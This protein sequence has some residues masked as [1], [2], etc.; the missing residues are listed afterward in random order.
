MTATLDEFFR[1]C[2]TPFRSMQGDIS[3]ILRLIE[4]EHSCS[5]TAA[6]SIPLTQ[7]I[8][9]TTWWWGMVEV[10]DLYGHPSASRCYAWRPHPKSRG[11][12]TMLKT[13]G[14]SSVEEAVQAWLHAA[15]R[16]PSPRG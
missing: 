6:A 14:I 10:F 9:R 8:G 4:R 5:A 11:F 13:G 1:R 2:A 16:S 7:V 3:E 12:V 15:R